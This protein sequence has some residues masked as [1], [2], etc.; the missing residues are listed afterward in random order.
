M[1]SDRQDAK[2]ILVINDDPAILTLFQDLLGDEGYTVTLDKFG[3]QT[4]ELLEVIR[5]LQPDLVI[6]DFIIGH[7]NS[8]WQLLQAAKM[9][10][11]T[12]DIPVVVCTG[13][14]RQVTELS[15][16]LDALDVHVV[17]KPFDIDHLIEVI[18][19]TWVSVDD[20][21]PGLDTISLED[22]QRLE[23]ED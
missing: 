8:G 7:E 12:R 10:R 6:M 5:T 1:T 16:H 19:K 11:E 21:V 2:H 17:I 18:A 23:E 4:G 9:D 20:P 15:Q 3:R 22:K 14:I 13:A